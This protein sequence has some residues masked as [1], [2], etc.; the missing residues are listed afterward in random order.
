[1]KRRIVMVSSG[2]I[3]LLLLISGVGTLPSLALSDSASTAQPNAGDPVIAAA[4]EIGQMGGVQAATAQLLLADHTVSN[5]IVL[6]DLTQGT[7]TQSDF[8][9]N[10]GPNWGKLSSIVLPTP[11]SH[12]YMASSPYYY[13][14]FHNEFGKWW[15]TN[16]GAWHIIS[17]NSQEDHSSASLQNAWLQR[18]LA[19]DNSACTL[20]F[21]NY[22]RFSSGTDF[23]N[24][25]SMQPLWQTL[26]NGNADVVL[27]AESRH[28]ERFNPMDPS[29]NLDATRGITSF[30]VGTGGASL[31]PA[32]QLQKNSAFRDATANGIL[33]LTLHKTSYD[34]SYV[35]TSGM[36]TDT[37]TGQ[38]H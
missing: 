25:T 15:S 38:C 14:L 34:W 35:T 8:M 22:P 23:G 2:L 13:Q 19:T 26:Y 31:N 12:E 33:K 30:V 17:L 36:V 11:G 29:G 9:T 6:G 16:I 4:G 3:S 18:D 32:D 5:V 24:D 21:E 28:Y 7:G 27:A 1:M 10:W 37:G 20:A